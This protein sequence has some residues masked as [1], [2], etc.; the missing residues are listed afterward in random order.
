LVPPGKGAISKGGPIEG[1]SKLAR[2]GPGV[3]VSMAGSIIYHVKVIFPIGL[4]LLAVFYLPGIVFV[5]PVIIVE[6]IVF[7]VPGD[8]GIQGNVFAVVINFVGIGY[9]PFLEKVVFIKGELDKRHIA[10]IIGLKIVGTEVTYI[11]AEAFVYQGCFAVFKA[12]SVAELKKTGLSE[13]GRAGHDQ[14]K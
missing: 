2:S 12:V 6:L 10:K 14:N 1:A 7:A 5:I 13:G 8:Y 9:C 11:V 3:V 4:H